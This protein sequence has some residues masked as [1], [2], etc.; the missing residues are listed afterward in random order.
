MKKSAVALILVVAV[1]LSPLARAET[2]PLSSSALQALRQN[3]VGAQVS[4][5]RI[6]Q[7][8]KPTRINRGY[9]YDRSLK[10]MTSLNSRIAFNN[11]E[12]PEL[13]NL[14]TRY[15]ESLKSFAEEYT[16]YDDQLSDLIALDC[17]QNPSQFYDMLAETRRLRS[18]LTKTINTIDGLLEDY[19]ANVDSVKKVVEVTS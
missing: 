15:Q 2:Q 18:D 3:C 6:Q 8:E 5:Q 1:L 9:L 7:S 10:L 11:I 19:R 14:T 4:L 12:S 16:K 13:F 17:T